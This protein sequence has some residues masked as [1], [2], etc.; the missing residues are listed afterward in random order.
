MKQ[1]DHFWKVRCEEKLST[2]IILI[3]ILKAKMKTAIFGNLLT[4]VNRFKLL[5][6]VK[7][8][9]DIIKMKGSPAN[10]VFDNIKG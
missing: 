2:Q 6:D 3:S 5:T 8:L 9:C 4:S 1:R 10:K 7:I